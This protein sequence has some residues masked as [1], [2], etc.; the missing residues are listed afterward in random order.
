M[1]QTKREIAAE[2]R[3]DR[4]E[5][6]GQILMMEMMLD[7]PGEMQLGFPFGPV[8]ARITAEVDCAPRRAENDEA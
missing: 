4:R 1:A 8:V 5:H 2:E 6:L 7:D 3:A